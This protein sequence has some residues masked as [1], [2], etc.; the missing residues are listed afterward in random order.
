MKRLSD[1]PIHLD[2]NFT[3]KVKTHEVIVTAHNM[4]LVPPNTALLVLKENGNR[5]ELFITTTNT[6]NA[7]IIIQYSPPN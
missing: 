1:K 3:E 2:F 6:F 5:Q 7:K 4:G